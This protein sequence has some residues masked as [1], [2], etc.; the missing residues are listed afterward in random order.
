MGW[1]KIVCVLFFFFSDDTNCRERLRN[2]R[3]GCMH[4]NKQYPAVHRFSL[5][6]DVL[7]S[8]LAPITRRGHRQAGLDD[9]RAEGFSGHFRNRR[10][11]LNGTYA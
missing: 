1:L 5:L 9:N 2:K 8:S 3:R 11:G 10:N 4:N 7:A 6:V